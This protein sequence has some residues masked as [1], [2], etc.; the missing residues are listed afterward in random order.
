MI[1]KL[2]RY[3]IYAFQRERVCSVCEEKVG[4]EL[5]YEVR[6]DGQSPL[7]ERF[8]MC[9]RCAFNASKE[10]FHEEDHQDLYEDI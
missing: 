8:F 5:A 7:N 9:P 1:A 10:M 6:W 3:L 2:W 4:R